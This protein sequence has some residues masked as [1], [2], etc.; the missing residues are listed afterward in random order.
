MPKEYEEIRDSYIHKGKSVKEA[1]KLAAMTYNKRHPGHANPWEHETKD[2]QRR[3][4][5]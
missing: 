5:K 1:K 2:M 3:V 4:R